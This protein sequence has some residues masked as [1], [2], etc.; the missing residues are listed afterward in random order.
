MCLS[1][2]ACEKVIEFDLS[3]SKEIIVIEATVTSS[4][5]PFTVLVSKTSPFFGPKTDHAVSGAKV[6]LRVENGKPKYFFET[7]PGVYKLEKSAALANY[8]Y[9]VDIEYEGITY[10]AR[11]FMNEPVPIVDLS[12]SYFDGFGFFD[13][14]YKATCFIRDP[15]NK[16]NYYRLKYYVNRK[17]VDDKGE[18]NLHSDKLFD[19]KVVGL[20]QRSV[21]FKE[22]D[23]LTIE[24]QTIDKTAYDYFLMLE[25]ISGNE[26]QQ[27]ASPANP[28]S[29]FNNGALGYFS[30]Y[31]YERKTVV[32][33]DYIKK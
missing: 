13:S 19:G 3:G 16:E 8:W 11:S 33:K 18:I 17:S 1:F 26:V 10:S 28:V 15:A 2:S 25:S 20:G 31:S 7:T 23:T 21:V 5:A 6:S 30:A 4:K 32:I 27:T 29:N 14:G 24:L 12:F 22:T 9:I